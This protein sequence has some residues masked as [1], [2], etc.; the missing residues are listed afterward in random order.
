[1]DKKDTHKVVLDKAM[2]KAMVQTVNA[3]MDTV[4]V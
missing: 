2:V 1:M 4:M 3:T